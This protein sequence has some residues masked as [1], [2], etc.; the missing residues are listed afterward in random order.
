MIISLFV[1]SSFTSELSISLSWVETVVVVLLREHSFLPSK[2]YSIISSMKI[3][4]ISPLNSK[5]PPLTL[6]LAETISDVLHSLMDTW[7]EIV[8]KCEWIFLFFDASDWRNGNLCITCRDNLR[9]GNLRQTRALFKD[10]ITTYRALEHGIRA[11]YYIC[12]TVR[13]S[14]L[15]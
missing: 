7:N 4:W 13:F 1:F 15:L 6:A 11:K 10:I 8:L 14:W 3:L 2:I 5:S 12:R 9:V